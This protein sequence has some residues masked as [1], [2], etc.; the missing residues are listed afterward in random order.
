MVDA[1][2]VDSLVK[3]YGKAPAVDNISFDVAKGEVFSLLGPNGAGK[4]T[5]IEIIE[6]IRSPTSG[7]VR[8]LG[9]D[10]S[11]PE[12]VRRI[13]REIGV[14]PQEFSMFENLKVSEVVRFFGSLYGDTSRVD[15]VLAAL[16]LVNDRNKKFDALSGGMKQ[17]VGIASAVV[18]DPEIAFLDEPTTGLDPRSRRDVWRFITGLKEKG[19]TVFLTTHY[20]EEAQLLSD[21]VAIVNRGKIAAIGTPKDLI[22]RY[23]G[24]KKVALRNVGEAAAKKLVEE[25][26]ALHENGSITIYLK[27][28]GDLKR[29]MTEAPF[30]DIEVITPSLED[31]FLKLAGERLKEG[32]A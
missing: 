16:D 3:M 9:Y 5:T 32:P 11:K 25:F 27:D 17:R 8:V 2:S 20:M 24:M 22:E 4:T 12:D 13:K 29:I 14:L 7:S 30:E 15:E 19:K 18:H 26:D 21:R 23:G 1:V 28:R 10:T 31:V 6:C